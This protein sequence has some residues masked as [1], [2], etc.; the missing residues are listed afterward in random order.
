MCVRI[1]YF[2]LLA[3][4]CTLY[5]TSCDEGEQTISPQRLNGRWEL[6][7][8]FRNKKETATL[9]GT[10]FL[11][12]DGA[13]MKTNLPVGPEEQMNYELEKFTILQKSSPPLKYEIITLSDT[14]LILGFELR[15]M[16]FELRLRRAST[17]SETDASQ[18]SPNPQEPVPAM[19]DTT[20]APSY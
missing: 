17:S 18:P 1:S 19:N 14:S 16:Q 13:K 20:S 7:Q 2:F 8:G 12:E 9:A 3:L 10:Y 11:F 4:S 15:G 6:A 5:C